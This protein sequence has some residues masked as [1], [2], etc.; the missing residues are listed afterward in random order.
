MAATSSHG[1]GFNLIRTFKASS[2]LIDVE[3]SLS[4]QNNI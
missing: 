2:R 3:K 1:E 4:V